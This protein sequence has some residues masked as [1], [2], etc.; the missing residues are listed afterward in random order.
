MTNETWSGTARR[1]AL[2]FG[3]LVAIVAVGSGVALA[4][5]STTRDAIQRMKEE[6]ESVRLAQELASAVRDQYAHQAHT[7]IIGDESHLGFYADAERRVL[8]LT[9]TLRARTESP[10][11]RRAVDA[12]DAATAELDDVFRTRIV[13]AVLGGDRALVQREH[14]RAQEVVTRI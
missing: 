5:L 6:E 10:E 14:A 8:E 1:L 11:A 4:G 7:I 12:I 9:R 3:S 13:P 2:G